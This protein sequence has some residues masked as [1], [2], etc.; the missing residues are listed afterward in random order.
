MSDRNIPNIFGLL[1]SDMCIDKP[2]VAGT[3]DG[4]FVVNKSIAN[5][6]SLKGVFDFPD[7]EGIRLPVTVFLMIGFFMLFR[8]IMTTFTVF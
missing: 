8:T 2:D 5:I 7:E 4:F 1:L 6:L 3:S